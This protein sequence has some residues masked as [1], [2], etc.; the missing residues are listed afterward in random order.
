MPDIIK[1][2]CNACPQPIEIDMNNI[3][4]IVYYKKL[5]YHKT[6]FCD[7]AKQKAESKK[8]KYADW[9]YALDNVTELELDAKNRLEYPF[10]KDCFN[11]YLLKNYNVVA[12]PD[13]LWEVAA[14]L[15][16]GIYKSKKC[17]PVSFKIL[18]EA[19]QWGQHKLN[20]INRQ[21]KIDR[22]GPTND[23]E[24]ILYDLA[25]LV[26]KIPNYL[27]HKA[28]IEAQQ[29]EIKKETKTSRINLNKVH[30]PKVESNNYFD[31][32]SSLLDEAF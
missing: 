17:K 7:L 25:I 28:K 16:S 8:G 26:R 4:N 27:S 1:R 10:I 12:V 24:R 23:E 6:C 32:I 5:Y 11:E 14:A 30:Q 19:W 29:A 20:K 13:R 15:E 21:N 2:K 22:R 18:Y 31:D 3:D 9:Q